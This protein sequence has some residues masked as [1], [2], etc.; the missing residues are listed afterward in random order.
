[1]N[2]QDSPRLLD[3]LFSSDATREVFSDHSRLQEMLHFE[4]ALA[5]AEARVGVI[6]GSA[7]P[8][9]ESQCRAELFD[10]EKLAREAALAGNL[11][12][13][14]VK[15]LTA[16]VASRDAGASRFVHWGAT[17]QDAI[18]TG[19]V[20]Q[21][22]A[23]LDL[24]EADLDRLSEALRTLAEAHTHTP[25]AGRTW[26]QQALPVT[27]G[28][29]AA[30]WF[31]AVERHRARIREMRPRVLVI[32]FGGAAGTLAALGTKGLQVAAALGEELKLGV[33]DLPWHAHR[34]RVAEAGTTLGLLVG[35][36]GKIA[37]DISLLMQTEVGEVYEPPAAGR[38]GSSTMPQKRNP[39][40]S[41]IALAA[42]LR[43]PA[44]VSV[45]LAAMLQENERGLGNWLAEWETLPEIF[46]LTAG[47]LGHMTRV[48]ENL[49]VNKEQMARNLEATHGQILAESVMMALGTGMGR[50]QA[51]ELVEKACRRAS[52]QGR[53]LR[54]ILREDPQVQEHLSSSDLERLFSPNN[55]LGLA[56]ALVDRALAMRSKH[57]GSD[58]NDLT[59]ATFVAVKGGRI[60]YRV[61]GKSDAPVLVLSNSLGTDLAMWEPQM[62]A[63]VRSFRVVR[64]DSRGHGASSVGAGEYTIE[65][66]ANDVFALVDHLGIANFSFCGLSMGGMVGMWLALNAPNRLNKLV[67]CSTAARIGTSESWNARI[68]MVCNNGVTAIVEP[69]LERW[70]T[71][72][73]LERE[74]AAVDRLR[75]MVLA[76]PPDGYAA[77]CAAVRDADFRETISRVRCRTLVIAGS[78]DPATPPKDGQFLAG[79]I[80]G[81][82]YVELDT[83]HL[84]NV[85]SPRRFEEE[86]LRFLVS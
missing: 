82:Q 72:A 86:V 24:I 69:L 3:P 70:F 83:A 60:Q 65:K 25:M 23:A 32:Q 5:R 59:A 75:R 33:P 18:D 10:F 8:A 76:T 35:T 49:E 34:D 2:P 71:R 22:R 44:L 7:V 52:E 77:S 74:P 46:N 73:F 36:L 66:L 53:H 61:D 4:A 6:P 16:L 14:L 64:Y 58:A 1:M 26:L 84:S 20:L 45:V 50:L 85:E 9:I 68:E 21:L 38:G 48:L 37:R 81:A 27:F 15:Q 40:G 67:L 39:V 19:L 62:P 47:A 11:A 41:A 54:D 80:P 51:H 30:G 28:L 56:E 78:Q 57:P 55:Y 17:S 12:I 43:V 29:K 79:Q 31:S 13:P 42:A 63:F